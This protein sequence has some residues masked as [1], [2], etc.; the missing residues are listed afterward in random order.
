MNRKKI[1]QMLVA[2]LIIFILVLFE[3]GYFFDTQRLFDVYTTHDMKTIATSENWKYLSKVNNIEEPKN[4]RDYFTRSK[5]I[6]VKGQLKTKGIY[7]TFSDHEEGTRFDYGIL[8]DGDIYP[9][10]HFV[11]GE[12]RWLYLGGEEDYTKY[13]ISEL[14][15]NDGDKNR[16]E[17]VKSDIFDSSDVERF[18]RLTKKYDFDAF[19]E[20]Y[21]KDEDYQ[22]LCDKVKSLSMEKDEK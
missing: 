2:M 22:Y 4:V 9:M 1:I 8:T 14:T 6:T 5:D 12:K 15:W 11:I 7:F 18:Q 3:H 10:R 19:E 13:S 20:R 21:L 17:I 16:S